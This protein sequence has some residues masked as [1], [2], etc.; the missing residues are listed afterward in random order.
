MEL[1][2]VF[3]DAGIIQDLQAAA[4]AVERQGV[5]NSKSGGEGVVAACCQWLRAQQDD[6]MFGGLQRARVEAL[7][8]ELEVLER[9]APSADNVLDPLEKTSVVAAKRAELAAAQQLATWR[10]SL[11]VHEQTLQRATQR[12]RGNKS[13]SAA[14]IEQPLLW[15]D[16]ALLFM[17][18][19][20]AMECGARSS[21]RGD[22]TSAVPRSPSSPVKLTTAVAS[23]RT[24]VQM[25]SGSAAFR[26]DNV[27]S[28]L[29]LD[30]ADSPSAS[31][32][33]IPEESK[34]QQQQQWF[35]AMCRLPYVGDGAH[36][37]GSTLLLPLMQEVRMRLGINDD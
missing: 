4:S 22:S 20:A 10:P 30:V 31:K 29:A 13:K 12:L 25:Q 27:A 15:R 11:Q 5:K 7:C 23:K 14:G 26:K 36:G 33:L 34:L 16:L 19:A 21:E 3:A 1:Q 24:S 28:P 32:A 18:Q 35:A 6:G 9:D 37:N 17:L 2:W 8:E